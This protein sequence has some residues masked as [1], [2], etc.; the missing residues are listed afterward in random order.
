M[1]CRDCKSDAQV[2]CIDSRLG[3]A[4]KWR[5][6]RYKCE[7]GLRFSSYE[8]SVEEL[9]ELAQWSGMVERKIKKIVTKTF[10]FKP[11]ILK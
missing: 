11:T 9:D 8:I 2:K 5:R 6:R 4:M 7:C 1:R 10:R 3:Q